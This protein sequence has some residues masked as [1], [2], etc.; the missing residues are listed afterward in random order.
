MSHL[1]SEVRP[2]CLQTTIA[3]LISQELSHTLLHCP[4]KHTSTRPSE[5][6]LSPTSRISV[7][8]QVEAVDILQQICMTLKMNTKTS[9]CLCAMQ[10]SE[11]T[12]WL[13]IVQVN[14][15]PYFYNLKEA[16]K[17]TAQELSS[18]YSYYYFSTHTQIR[19]QCRM[20]L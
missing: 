1:C 5:L 17:H 2:S 4:W 11:K 13:V 16:N 3:S 18:N 20:C 19:D 8:L 12:V 10:N 15:P 7:L 9:A 14:M 6:F